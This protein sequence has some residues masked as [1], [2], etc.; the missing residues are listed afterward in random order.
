MFFA[1]KALEALNYLHSIGVYYGDMKP[2]NIL[3]FRDY[4]VKLG[5][6]GISIK[7]NINEPDKTAYLKGRTEFYSS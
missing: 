3:I 4:L 5:D 7:M 2:A 6:F 1:L